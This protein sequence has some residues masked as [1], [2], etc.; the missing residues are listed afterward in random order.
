MIRLSA[1]LVA[2]VKLPRRLTASDVEC[3]HRIDGLEE[4]G[5]GGI[6]SNLMLGRGT[7][8]PIQDRG[9]AMNQP[10][11]N[12]DNEKDAVSLGRFYDASTVRAIMSIA[13]M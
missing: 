2:P 11:S 4:N 3:Q 10:I 7:S 13:S 6:T 9:V 1:Y 5:T 8:I 12:R